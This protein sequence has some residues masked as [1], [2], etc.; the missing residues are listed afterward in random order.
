MPQQRETLD[1]WVERAIVLGLPILTVVLVI[2]AALWWRGRDSSPEDT[3]LAVVEVTPS[4]VPIANPSETAVETP[5]VKTLY[6]AGID[7]AM[8][9]SHDLCYPDGTKP[10]TNRGYVYCSPFHVDHFDLVRLLAGP[11]KGVD[12]HWY[13][14]VQVIKGSMWA[15]VGEEDP[16]GIW[17]IRESPDLFIFIAQ[18]VYSSVG[19]QPT[20]DPHLTYRLNWSYLLRDGVAGQPIQ[21]RKGPKLVAGGGQKVTFTGEV[22]LGMSKETSTTWWCQ[23]ASLAETPIEIYLAHLPAEQQAKGAWVP[24][25]YTPEEER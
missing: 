17:W 16:P 1:G 4:A 18:G 9:G 13:W 23:L 3:A 21:G 25:E 10:W 14:R 8:R 24:C 5:R 19:L 2:L 12:G 20:P 7:Y 22:G 6:P 15:E 11:E